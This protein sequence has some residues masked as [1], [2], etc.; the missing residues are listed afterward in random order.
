MTVLQTYERLEASG[1]WRA[2]EDAQRRDVVVSVGDATLTLYDMSETALAHWSLPAVERLNPGQMPAVYAPGAETPDRLEIDDQNMVEA[3]ETV[4]NAILKSRGQPGRLRLAITA[5]IG[6][7][8]LLLGTFWLPGAMARY[9]TSILPEATRTQ[10]GQDMMAHVRRVAGAPCAAPSGN[11]ALFALEQRL[12][13]DGATRLRIMPS[14]VE[15]TAHLPGGIILL[16]HALVEDHETPDVAAGYALAEA[17]RRA[18]S[19]PAERFLK[20]AGLRATLSLL[21]TGRVSAPALQDHAEAL[22]TTEEDPVDPKT[23]LSAFQT[24]GV[25]AKAYAFAKDISGETTLPLIEGA[26]LS[27]SARPLLSDGQW[28]ALQQICDG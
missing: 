28:I 11:R 4:R 16:G 10:M 18:A 17:L 12:F 3:I 26:E 21:T 7:L 22:L 13:P 1:L 27:S 24:V 14:G 5:S 2:D 6:V 19:D 20:D 15:T 9:A 25:S 23:L 8:L